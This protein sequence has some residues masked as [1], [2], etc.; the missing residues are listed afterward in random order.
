[1][2][3]RDWQRHELLLTLNLYCK[4]PFGQYHARNPEIARLA[5]FIQRTPDAVAMKLSNFA[6]LDPYHQQRGI[7]GLQNISRADREIWEEFHSDW[8]ALAVESELAYT[9]VVEFEPLDD[10][11]SPQAERETEVERQVRVR[12]GQAFFRKVMLTSY[13]QQCCVCALPVPE[14]LVASH[15]LPWRDA[16]KQRLNPH[17]G[18]CLCVLHDRGFDRGFVT[19]DV[20]YSFVVGGALGRYLPDPALETYFSAYH[21]QQIQMPDKFIPSQ[22]FLTIHREHYFLG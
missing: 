20:D 11:E 3:R 18:L 1:M 2:T 15:I 5:H 17:N 10:D 6:S 12:V 4:L 22:E 8:S 19:F 14:M 13:R 9:D 16:E 21:G 7:K